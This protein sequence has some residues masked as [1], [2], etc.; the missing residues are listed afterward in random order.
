MT[1]NALVFVEYLGCGLREND[2][3]Q[4]VV[5]AVILIIQSDPLVE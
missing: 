1:R 2:H 3:A 4:G 5:D